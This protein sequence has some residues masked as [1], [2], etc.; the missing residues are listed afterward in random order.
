MLSVK[1]FFGITTMLLITTG[2]AST[3]G[4][5]PVPDRAQE[6]TTAAPST[7]ER[8]TTLPG[9]A[10][11]TPAT[12]SGPWAR[13]N[14][15]IKGEALIRDSDGGYL[16]EVR[17]I[18]QGGGDVNWQMQSS[19]L[20]PLMAAAS[21]GHAEVVRFLLQQG[22]DPSLRD[23]SG[24]TAL[25]LAIRDGANDVAQILREAMAISNGAVPPRAGDAPARPAGNPGARA[26]PPNPEDAAPG[27]TTA[28]VSPA[29]PTRWAPFGT[30]RVGD[31]VQFRLSNGWRTGTVRE[32]G[33]A[34]DYGKRN[35]GVY[36]RKYRIADDRYSDAGDWQDWGWVAGTTREPFWTAFFVGDWKLGEVMAVNTR[37]EGQYERSEYSYH[38]ASEALR[39]SANGSYLWKPL[40]AE[41]ISGRWTPADDGPGIVLLKGVDGRDWTLR[42]ETNATEENIRGLESARLT[43]EGKMSITALRPIGGVAARGS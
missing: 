5:A 26:T 28:A 11:L 40:G 31:R 12:P 25:D 16:Q 39:V 9:A 41:A 4:C 19:G 32:V 21:G 38:A 29:P 24:K 6:T 18:V 27:A 42:N 43:T 23:A 33:S 15:K 14:G 1:R 17:S 20:T 37:R 36:E 3:D 22:A 30:Y 10:E 34:G 2:Q 35:A 7:P 13:F 8:D